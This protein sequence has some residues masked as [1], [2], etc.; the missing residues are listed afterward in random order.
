[1]ILFLQCVAE[2]AFENGLRGL[3]E[4]VPGGKYACDLAES[5]WKKY[6]QRCDERQQRAEILEMAR[7][8]ID[9]AAQ[10]AREAIAAGVP[11]ATPPQDVASLHLFL[12]GIPDAVRQSLKRPEDPGGKSVPGAFALTSPDD[13]MRLLPA[14]PPR[15]RPNDPLPGKPGWVLE[16]LLGTGGFG[17]VW[18]A[19]HASMSSLNGAVKFCLGESARDLIHEAGL[20]DRVMQA[21]RHPNLVP[22]TDVHLDG[23]TPW[24][25]FEYVAGGTLTDFIH[26][27]AGKPIDVR[28][29]QV[30][31]ALKQLCSAVTV[32]HGMEPAV[33]HRDLKPSN[34]LLDRAAKTLRITDFGIGAVTARETLRQESRGQ[35]TQ[36]GRLLSYLR[37]SHTPLYASPQQRAGADPDPR[38]DV[39]ALGVI[40]YQMLTGHLTQ[41]AGPDF[42]DDLREAGAG[43]GLIDL[44]GRCVA[45]KPERRPRDAREVVERLT[46]LE[47]PAS[48]AAPPREQP[49]R[50]SSASV[51]AHEATVSH[52]VTSFVPASVV[53]T[54]RRTITTRD[55]GTAPDALISPS[56]GVVECVAYSPDG[57]RVVSGSSDRTLKVWDAATGREVLTLKGHTDEVRGVA[58][59]PDGR[60]IVSGSRDNQL[61]VWE[62][63][64][65][66]ELLTLKG[67]ADLVSSVALSPDGRQVVSGS[68]DKTLRIWEVTAR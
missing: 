63:V 42:A 11:A 2:A 67:H 10:Q 57:R 40:G 26:V 30:L 58:F 22:L 31:A 18:H 32:F 14:R 15:F 38:D 59:G 8:A 33:V 64:T 34:V 50:K 20:I 28:V 56:A 25:M 60:W 43:E 19:R 4:M 39:H 37:G 61:K 24:L 49:H 6:R 7:S 23:P 53:I 35:S 9:T 29:K 65:G 66:Q 36:G 5:A 16:R 44:L 17:E 46:N 27:V 55:S 13:L 62:A 1:M 68:W 41:G 21:G 45:Q 52:K 51:S 47:P 12:T 54:Q 48:P 3:A